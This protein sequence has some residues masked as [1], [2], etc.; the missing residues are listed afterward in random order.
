MTTTTRKTRKA[1]PVLPVPVETSSRICFGIC[2]FASEADADTYAA[3]VQARGDTYN[4]GYCDGMGCGR[5]RRFDYLHPVH[6]KL[7]AV[8]TR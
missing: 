7:Y 2:Y 5:E 6:G 4:G 8:T 3:H 1:A